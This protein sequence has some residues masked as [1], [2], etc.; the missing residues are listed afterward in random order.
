MLLLQA[1]GLRRLELLEQDIALGRQEAFAVHVR[2]AA[3]TPSG[4]L[5]GTA[6]ADRSGGIR[7]DFMP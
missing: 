2:S 6:A 4:Y 1:V 7:P 3:G 5:A